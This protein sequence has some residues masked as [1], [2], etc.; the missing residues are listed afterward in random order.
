MIKP[1]EVLKQMIRRPGTIK[2]YLKR[3]NE[4]MADIDMVKPVPI[5]A[6][7]IPVVFEPTQ[8]SVSD[9]DSIVKIFDNFEISE[10]D[11]FIDIGCGK[12]AV[13]SALSK[14]KFNQIDGIEYSKEVFQ[15][16]K[17]NIATL[18]IKNT[19][20]YNQNAADFPL[21]K[22]YTHIYMYNPFGK[23][24]MRKVIDKIEQTL[25]IN[26]RSIYIIYANPVY[27]LEIIKH[28]I[29]QKSDACFS[30]LNYNIHIYKNEIL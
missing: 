23:S 4:Y 7:G 14:F 24:I 28:D 26:N 12:G 20:I 13:I 11:A 25:M 3:V 2:Y 5:S 10:N 1:V 30:R 8:Y 19:T 27:H 17:R 18:K 22:K 21:Y 15:I 6:L 9:T 29:F 16:A